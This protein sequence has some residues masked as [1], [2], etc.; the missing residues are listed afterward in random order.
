[1]LHSRRVKKYRGEKSET[2]YASE[3]TFSQKES[4]VC[5]SKGSGFVSLEAVTSF[6]KSK[7]S[8]FESCRNI[9]T[10]HEMEIT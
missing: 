6:M 8:L 5:C 7:L 10:L 3:V 2:G 1:M 4:S 9:N